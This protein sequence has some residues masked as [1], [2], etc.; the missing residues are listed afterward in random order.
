MRSDHRLHFKHIAHSKGWGTLHSWP[1]VVSLV[2]KHRRSSCLVP[3]ECWAADL[4][5]V[6]EL[7]TIFIDD[8]MR[9]TD[10][11]V[12]TVSEVIRPWAVTAI[13]LCRFIL[14]TDCETASSC[15]SLVTCFQRRTLFGTIRFLRSATWT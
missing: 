3:Q 9:K 5:Q 13:R 15:S 14:L 7:M 2:G 11:P 10:D 6:R 12:F 8:T 4:D 1:I